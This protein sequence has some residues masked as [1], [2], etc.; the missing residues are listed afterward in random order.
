MYKRQ[1]EGFRHRVEAQ[2][3]G[4]TYPRGT[5]LA[6]ETY[7]A[8]NGGVNKYGSDVMVPA[9]LSTYTSRGGHSLDLFP[10]ITRLRCV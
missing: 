3:Q 7:N 5:S 8:A 1:L 9:F 10:A 2:Y 6:G 4:A